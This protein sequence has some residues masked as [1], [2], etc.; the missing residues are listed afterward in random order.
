MSRKLQG[1]K[2]VRTELRPLNRVPLVESVATH[3]REL[4]VDGGFR[5]GDRLPSEAGLMQQ[6]QVSRPVL[7]EAVNRLAAI[8]L[9]SVR[10]GSGTYVAG[11][12]W[13]SSCTRLAGSSLV[14]GPQELLQFVE[15]RRVIESYA[16]PRAAEM[17][18]PEQLKELER[19]YERAM[20]LVPCEPHEVIESDLRFHGM[21]IEIGGNPLMRSMMEL[22]QEFALA[23]M[24]RTE[25]G[26]S[27]SP[28]QVEAHNQ[29]SRQLHADIMNAVRARDPKAAEQ[30]IHAHMDL[31]TERLKA[32]EAADW[33]TGTRGPAAPARP[34][35]KPT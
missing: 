35:K 24:K 4:I 2:R 19:L 17:I 8:G 3:L 18:T 16:A 7:R 9:L 15:F 10:H 30:A 23:S 21:L 34:K 6:L 29:A 32:S 33:P 26:A 5:A 14:I 28:E 20:R 22:L 1:P 25:A 11:R 13:L 12:E 27:W 31:V